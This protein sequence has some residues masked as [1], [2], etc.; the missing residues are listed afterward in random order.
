MLLPQ[1]SSICRSLRLDRSVPIY[2]RGPSHTFFSTLTSLSERTLSPYRYPRP[3]VTLPVMLLFSPVALLTP[4]LTGI[5]SPV[6]APLTLHSCHTSLRAAPQTYIPA[7]GP[8]RLLVLLPTGPSPDLRDFL[9]QFKCHLLS[10]ALPDHPISFPVLSF[11]S[12]IAVSTVR[13]IYLLSGMSPI[14][15]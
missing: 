15:L 9:P 1:G 5:V 4:G 13:C 7:S 6:T 11:F 3:N 12:F 10:E 14:R 2:V 8:L